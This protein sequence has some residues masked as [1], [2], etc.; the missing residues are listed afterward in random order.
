[1]KLT[2]CPCRNCEK[3]TAECR[4][5]CGRYKVY[6]TAKMKEYEE[7]KKLSD[8]Y[9]AINDH[10]IKTKER[11]RKGSAKYTPKKNGTLKK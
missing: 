11:C 1:M 9:T 3:R 10:I 7:R 5:S 2:N 8:Q 6:H 4:I